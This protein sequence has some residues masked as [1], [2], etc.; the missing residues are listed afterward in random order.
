MRVLMGQYKSQSGE[1]RARYT[2]E[3]FLSQSV[4]H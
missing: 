3:E 1:S 4:E 2:A